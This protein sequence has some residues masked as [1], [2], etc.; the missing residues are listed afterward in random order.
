MCATSSVN[1]PYRGTLSSYAY[2]LL[3]IH[4][5]QT[6]SPAILPCLQ[7]NVDPS[8]PRVM[9]GEWDCT[10]VHDVRPYLGTAA[11]RPV[12]SRVS[13]VVLFCVCSVSCCEA[14][15]RFLSL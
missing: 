6:R 15:T 10:F 2:I 7:A 11:L 1:D 5:L 14:D 9:V 8:A 12:M 4:F 13:S 3:T